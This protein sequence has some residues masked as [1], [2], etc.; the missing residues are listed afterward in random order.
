MHSLTPRR[1]SS[2]GVSGSRV[3]H[4]CCHASEAGDEERGQGY[5]E[6]S[7]AIRRELGDELGVAILV[8][9]LAD[10]ALQGGD[11]AAAKAL[12]EETSHSCRM[13]LRARR[14]R[15]SAHARGSSFRTGDS[16]ESERIT[17]EE[18]GHVPSTR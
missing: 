9:D 15:R 16:G 12:S 5:T 3:A 7:L 6:E 11:P 8:A 13:V 4:S 17:L 10:R 2:K 18:P 14:C 1:G